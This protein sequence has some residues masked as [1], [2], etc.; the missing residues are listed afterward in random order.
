[1]VVLVVWWLGLVAGL[2]FVVDSCGFRLRAF[3]FGIMITFWLG[4]WD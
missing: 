1:M 2:C 3:G 4:G